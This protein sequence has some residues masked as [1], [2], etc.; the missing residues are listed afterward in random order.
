M[1]R[2]TEKM[3]YFLRKMVGKRMKN[4]RERGVL[5]IKIPME[6]RRK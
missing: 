3:E 4:R 1:I 2:K 5:W 6:K